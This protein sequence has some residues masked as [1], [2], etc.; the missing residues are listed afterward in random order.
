MWFKGSGVGLRFSSS[1]LGKTQASL[2]LRTLLRRFNG[3]T[4][5]LL[6]ANV[7][8]QQL[9]ILSHRW[10]RFHRYFFFGFSPALLLKTSTEDKHYFFHCYILRYLFLFFKGRP[11]DYCFGLAAWLG[12]EPFFERPVPI[13]VLYI[14]GLRAVRNLWFKVHD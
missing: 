4:C 9:F 7:K 6:N 13:S 14:Q 5:Y 11:A 3:L 8:C 12:Q 10:H 2:V 1:S